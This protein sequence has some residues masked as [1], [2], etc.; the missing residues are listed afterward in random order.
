[1]MI[2]DSGLLFGPPCS[3]VFEHISLTA[4]LLQGFLQ[5]QVIYST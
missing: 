4:R 1:M 5:V 2:G 3:S